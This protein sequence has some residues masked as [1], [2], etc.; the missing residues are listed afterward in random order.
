MGI[1]VECGQFELYYVL[2]CGD[3]AVGES[4][5]LLFAGD[6]LKELQ[7]EIAYVDKRF[8]ALERAKRDEEPD[9]VVQ[10][11]DHLAKMLEG[12]IRPIAELP[13]KHLVQAFSIHGKKWTRIRSDKMRNHWR[14]YNVDKSLLEARTD[15]NGNK[16]LLRKEL[17]AAMRNASRKI[18]DDLAGGITFKGQIAKGSVSGTITDIWHVSWLKWVDAVNDSLNYSGS[19]GYHDLSAGAQLLRGYAGFGIELGYNPKKN[20]YGLTGHAEAG[21]ILAEA[22]ARFDGYVPHRDGW[23]ALI[24]YGAPKAS[25]AGKQEALDFGYFRGRFSIVTHAMLG[26]SIFGTAGIEYVPQS[27]GKVLAK[28]S[29]AGPKGQ[30]AAG[31]FIGVEAGG[32]VSGALEWQNPGW[33]EGENGPIQDAKW[34]AIVEI[35]VAV[36]GNAGIGAE[37]DFYI[38]FTGTKLMFRARAELVVGLGAKGSLTGTIGFG[39]IYDFIMYVYH[40]LKDNDFSYLKFMNK[41]AFNFVVGLVLYSIESGI[42]LA[43]LTT[44]SIEDLYNKSLDMLGEIMKGFAD[45]NAAETYARRIKTRPMALIFAPPEAKGAVLHRLSQTFYFSFEEHQEAAVLTVVGTIQSKREWEQVV[46][47]ITAT[48]KKTSAAAGMARLNA[49]LDGGSQRS[50]NVLLRAINSLPPVTRY[51]GEPIII[52]NLA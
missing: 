29:A 3:S 50:F 24:P 16:I 37:V 8:A 15:A 14:S 25:Q 13:D 11:Q 38:E 19:S 12:Y 18:K 36:T 21:A 23:N 34:A 45:S 39:T 40:Q 4:K 52:R 43:R 47:R 2:A 33:R 10:A 5:I 30:V 42:D 9:D 27:D 1:C 49:I 48:G 7:A 31:F 6:E 28:P 51:A 32:G 26:A 35:G 20:S 17:A 41:D 22:K 44:D 46:E